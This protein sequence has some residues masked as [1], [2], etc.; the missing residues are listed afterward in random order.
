MKSLLLLFLAAVLPF[1]AL[2]AEVPKITPKEAD[3]LVS[4]G[5]AVLVDV[6]EP[7]EW[8]ETGVVEKAVLLPKSDFDGSQKLWKEFLAQTNGK[9]V[10]LY[11]RSGKRA[12]VIGATLAAKGIKVAN[13]G[14]F[15]DWEAAG[16]PTRKIDPKS[17]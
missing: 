14:G 4:E 3:K 1:K 6:R 9:E 10:I 11:C 5:K 7:A 16:L 8:A 17:P 2:A 13:A 12:G 15:S